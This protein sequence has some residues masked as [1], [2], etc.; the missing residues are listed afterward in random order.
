MLKLKC[1]KSKDVWYDYPKKESLHYLRLN[2]LLDPASLK[3]GQWMIVT[4]S[5]GSKVLIE[6]INK[7]DKYGNLKGA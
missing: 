6:C 3:V 1:L 7:G 5:N 4:D 2:S